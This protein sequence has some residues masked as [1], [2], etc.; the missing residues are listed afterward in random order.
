MWIAALAV[1]SLIWCP[2]SSARTV[3]LDEALKGLANGIQ[4]R[5]FSKTYDSLFNALGRLNELYRT[6][7]SIAKPAKTITGEIT[8][9]LDAFNGSPKELGSLVT[10]L[11]ADTKNLNDITVPVPAFGDPTKG[12]ATSDLTSGDPIIRGTALDKLLAQGD[13]L[14][15]EFNSTLDRYQ[16]LQKTANETVNEAMAAEDR[17][18]ALEK[19]LDKLDDSAAGFVLN[20]YGQH[21]AFMALDMTIAVNPALAQRTSAAKALAKRYADAINVMRDKLRQYRL[22]ESWARF[23]RWQEWIRQYSPLSSQ[24]KEAEDILAKVDTLGGLSSTG[25]SP[26]ALAIAQLIKKTVQETGATKAQAE[27]LIEQAARKDAEAAA[28]Q[29]HQALL[30]L[31]G[32]VSGLGSNVA[33]GAGSSA[34]GA[35]A[36]PSDSPPLLVPGVMRFGAPGGTT[37]QSP[38]SQ[39]NSIPI[40]PPH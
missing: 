37:Q 2:A 40:S 3:P 29:E 22:Y 5:D 31:I 35:A 6:A 14:R 17:G 4:Q 15:A 11:E 21:L 33:G 30:G 26:G 16:R 1:L 7:S 10:M 32:A 24:L 27:R 34:A 39:P 12:V 13:K 38:D 9:G 36:A 19:V 20:I 23:Y 8:R 18:V 25:A 28:Q